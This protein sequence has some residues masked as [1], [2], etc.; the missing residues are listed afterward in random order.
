[1]KRI[2]FLIVVLFSVM[3]LHAQQYYGMV[4]DPDGYANIR[5]G[6]STSS[7]IVSRYQSGYYL[8]YTPDKNGWCKVYSGTSSDT[9]MGYMHSSRIMPV[10]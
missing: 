8:Y 6:P 5:K 7:P 1:M 4:S 9:F 2:I 3:G 10:N